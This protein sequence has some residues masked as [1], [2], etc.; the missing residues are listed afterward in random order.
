MVAVLVERQIALYD[1]RVRLLP[2]EVTTRN[3]SSLS[4]CGG[5]GREEAASSS[6]SRR[7]F[8]E[9]FWWYNIFVR[10]INESLIHLSPLSPATDIRVPLLQGRSRKSFCATPTSPKLKG[11]SSSRWRESSSAESVDDC[12]LSHCC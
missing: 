4:F 12:Q 8:R 11:S 7:S 9:T 2:D 5:Y 10:E 6:S 1:V 3:L